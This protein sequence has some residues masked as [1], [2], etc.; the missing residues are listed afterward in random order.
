MR[1]ST[2]ASFLSS[3]RTPLAACVASIFALSAPAATAII[4]STYYVDTCDEGISNTDT[5][6]GSLRWALTQAVSG[7]TIDMTGLNI[8]NCPTSTISLT[9]SDLKVPQDNLSIYGPGASALTI[10][11]SGIPFIAF[12]NYP[13]VFSHH[14][15]GTLQISD[16]TLTG[17]YNSHSA[18][19]TVGGC[20]YSEGSITLV[21][22]VVS[23]CK[24]NQYGGYT[25]GGAGVYTKGDLSLKYSTLTN[26]VA[27]GGRGGGAWARGQINAFFSTISG[28]KVYGTAGGGLSGDGNFL[29]AG[30]TISGNYSNADAGGIDASSAS[31]GGNSFELASSTISGNS[32]KNAGGGLIVN[33]AK[34]EFYNST[35]AFNTTISGS[36]GASPGV[37]L[38]ASSGDMGVYL[39]STL[40]SNNTYGLLESDLDSVGANTIKFN[41]GD[42][43]TAANNLIRVTIFSSAIPTVLPD[44]TL[45]DSC[46]RLGPLRDNGG[47]TWT[48]ALQS[49]SPA[50]DSGNDFSG[51]GYDQRG[52]AKYNGT[53]DY[54]R[55]SGGL[56]AKPDIGAYEVQQYDVVFNADME[57]CPPVVI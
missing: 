22:S 21:R 53:V 16:V 47:L 11:A 6:H 51:T 26:N 41:G 56:D 36:P 48:H 28:N 4:P 9:T 10:D 5:T 24:V 37:R 29:L 20:L 35:I 2:V 32:A 3:R 55:P 19:K 8:S 25:S 52:S 44:D 23:A 1:T 45:F 12:A 14:G 38:D 33:S 7:N 54:L 46:P 50:I 39:Q 42:K 31:P 15:T 49:G 18:V 17:S 34:A 13:R 40:M 27:F 43:A 57:G 30:T